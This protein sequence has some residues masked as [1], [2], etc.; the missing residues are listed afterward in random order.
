MKIRLYTKILT[1]VLIFSL[2]FPGH[3]FAQ[4]QDIS[5]KKAEK[6]DSYI[7][8]VMGKILTS[9]NCE[10]DH[11]DEDQK[12]FCQVAQG[13]NTFHSSEAHGDL[14]DETK[15][16]L[17]VGILTGEFVGL[18]LISISYTSWKDAR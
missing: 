18:L 15:K 1:W 11:L 3:S 8:G 10:D 2:S 4:N 16:N 7:L 12:Y 17:E 6:K 5:L 14:S 9:T 13:Q